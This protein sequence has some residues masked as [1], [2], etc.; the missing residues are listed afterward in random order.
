M[1][2]IKRNGGITFISAFGFSVTICR[3]AKAEKPRYSRNLVTRMRQRM[4][5]ME[6]APVTA[7]VVLSS[8]GASAFLFLSSL[9]TLF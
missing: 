5:E 7:P 2:T 4:A 1:I 9:S 8:F 3:K 6:P